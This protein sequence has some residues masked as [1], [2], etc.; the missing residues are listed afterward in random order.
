MP[1]EE[2]E[3][4]EVGLAKKDLP[5]C[6]VEVTI[7]VLCNKWRFLIVRD[8]LNGPMRFNELQKSLG[9]ITHKVLTANLRELEQD[10]VVERTVFAEV[11]PKTL[12]GLTEK[13]R[14]LDP[15]LKAMH[16][17]GDYFRDSLEDEG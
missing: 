9:S 1:V 16:L 2:M 5:P 13:G 3:H 10:E 6:P 8:L 15:V 11:P 12:Y 17:W 7:R 4:E 14:Q